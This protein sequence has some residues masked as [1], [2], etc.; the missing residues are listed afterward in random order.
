MSRLLPRT[1]NWN[2]SLSMINPSAS[3]RWDSSLTA[4][5]SGSRPRQQPRHPVPGSAAIQINTPKSMFDPVGPQPYR[6]PAG[7]WVTL[8]LHM[9]A[10]GRWMCADG[11]VIARRDGGYGAAE[12]AGRRGAKHS[13]W[14]AQRWAWRATARSSEM[15]IWRLNPRRIDDEFYARPVGSGTAADAGGM[16]RR[17]RRG[18]PVPDPESAKQLASLGRAG[19][20]EPKAPSHRP[21][22]PRP[23]AACCAPRRNTIACGTRARSTAPRWPMC[24]STFI[25]WLRI[26]GV[27]P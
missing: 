18:V 23:K 2:A 10:S 1:W 5:C 3:R 24:F 11:Q 25:G 6:I 12:S 7:P 14:P 15:K 27:S 9:M 21:G 16:P 17:D 22:S 20:R 4:M 8:A 26:A 13:R 19:R